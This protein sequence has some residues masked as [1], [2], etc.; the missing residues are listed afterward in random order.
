MGGVQ[1]IK[2][3]LP[4][5]GM[6]KGRCRKQNQKKADGRK[7]KARKKQGPEEEQQKQKEKYKAEKVIPLANGRYR[8]EMYKLYKGPK[9]KGGMCVGVDEGRERN[10]SSPR[11]REK[12]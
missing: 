10:A 3:D 7:D 2:E 1:R 5:E 4:R 9:K 11:K 8:L 6:E 12:C